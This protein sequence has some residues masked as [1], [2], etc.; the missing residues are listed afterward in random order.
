[1][2]KPGIGQLQAQGVLPVDPGRDRLRGLPIRE[3]LAVVQ[4]QQHRQHRR[5]Q[6]G[7]A[8][9]R[10]QICEVRVGEHRPERVP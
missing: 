8:A 5:R 7:L 3:V 4:Q 1:M 6:T 9:S 10:E 2:I